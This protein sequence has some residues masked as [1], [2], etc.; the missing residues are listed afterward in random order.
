VRGAVIFAHGVDSRAVAEIALVFSERGGIEEAQALL[1]LGELLLDEIVGIGAHQPLG[2]IVRLDH[3]KPMPGESAP[4][5]RHVVEQM[6]LRNDVE[7]GGTRDLFRMV[8]A[9]AVE[10]AGAAIMAGGVEALEPQ[11]GHHLELILRHGA[12]RIAAVVCPARRLFRIS[13]AAQVGGDNGELACQA[14]R[15]FV[16]GQV[17]EW[18]AVHQE[19]WRPLAATHGHDARAAGLDLG[20]DEPLEHR[21]TIGRDGRRG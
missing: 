10:H 5:P 21:P 1:G 20:A 8:E 17:R 7:N 14:R 9:H 11:R 19:Q 13:I 4:L 3:E 12:E 16:P 6:M 15:D 18:V 2:K